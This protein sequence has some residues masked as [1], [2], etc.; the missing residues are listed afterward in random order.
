[1]KKATK[2]GFT[3]VALSSEANE[4]LKALIAEYK[5]NSP[6]PSAKFPVSSVLE[7][8]IKAELGRVKNK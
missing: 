4:A 7:E 6:T 8:L 2:T 5:K 3:S 1:M